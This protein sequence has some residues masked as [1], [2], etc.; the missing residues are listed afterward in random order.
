MAC[1]KKNGA[2]SGMTDNPKKPADKKK[3]TT[4]TGKKPAGKCK[5]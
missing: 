2:G 4:T 3:G 5:K 1:N